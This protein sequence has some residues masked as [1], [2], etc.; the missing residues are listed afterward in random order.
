MLIL[1]A[2]RPVLIVPDAN[3]TADFRNI[4]VAWKDTREWRRVIMD[5]LPILHRV[6]RVTVVEVSQDPIAA[7][8][9]IRDIVAW[10]KRGGPASRSRIPAPASIPAF[11]TDCLRRGHLAVQLHV[12]LV[13]MPPPVPE[14]SHPAHPLAGYVASEHRT[15]PVH[16]EPHRLVADVDAALK[17]QV[18]DIP[19][20]KREAYIHH[21]HETDYLRGRVEATERV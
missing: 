4:V 13:E 11:A 21:H 16:P 7:C 2:G 18:L 8:D 19:E 14:A 10:L 15:E 17:Q 5:A 20:A 12:N 3:A 1:L 6:E 9:G